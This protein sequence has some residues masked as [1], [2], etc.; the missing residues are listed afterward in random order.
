MTTFT[1]PS[2]CL[3]RITVGECTCRRGFPGGPSWMVLYY[4]QNQILQQGLQSHR[5]KP[6]VL[7]SLSPCPPSSH[8][9]FQAL[10]SHFPFFRPLSAP[11]PAPPPPGPWN[12]LLSPAHRFHCLCL[13]WVASPPRDTALTL[14]SHTRR[15][16]PYENFPPHPEDFCTAPVTPAMPLSQLVDL[17]LSVDFPLSLSLWTTCSARH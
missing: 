2:L 16:A 14:A 6:W 13:C 1:N 4:S 7:H 17:H 11:I 10:H 5:D 8:I 15:S 3:P 12:M 9:T